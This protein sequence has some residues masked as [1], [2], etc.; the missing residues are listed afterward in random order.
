MWTNWTF[1][2]DATWRGFRSFCHAL[3]GLLVLVQ[4][5]QNTSYAIHIPWQAYLYSS[6]I[7]GLISLLQSVD[8]ERAVEAAVATETTA[9]QTPAADA[10]RMSATEAQLAVFGPGCGGDQ[11]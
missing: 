10:G 5:S 11:R 9:A 1:W 3:A 7:A 6:A 2:K 4:A 8:R